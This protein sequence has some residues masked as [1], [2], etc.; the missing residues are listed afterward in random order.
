MIGEGAVKIFFSSLFFALHST[1]SF[2]QFYIFV[3]II[4]F[5]VLTAINILM[6]VSVEKIYI[7]LFV[8]LIGVL[9]FKFGG[10]PA[11]SHTLMFPYFW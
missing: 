2:F 11:L 5:F 6:F 10:C 4:I 1:S 9:V 3:F 7:L 8:L